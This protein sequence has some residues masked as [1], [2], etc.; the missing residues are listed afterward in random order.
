MRVRDRPERRIA[1]RREIERH[2]SV[3]S[4]RLH[5]VER[6]Q[7][8]DEV[9][10]MLAVGDGL[11]ERRLALLEEQRRYCRSRDRGGAPAPSITA[12]RERA[13]TGAACCAMLFSQQTRAD[14]LPAAAPWPLSWI[15]VR[16]ARWRGTSEVQLARDVASIGT[17][18]ESGCASVPDVSC[19]VISS[20]NVAG[21]MCMPGMFVIVHARRHPSGHRPSWPCWWARHQVL[22]SIAAPALRCR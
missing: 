11:D 2:S 7:L 1:H 22:G 9:V 21:S 12:R 20:R 6:R 3:R 13:Q 14:S 8:H 10:R 16:N 4:S 19:A 15:S 17:G 5:V 18:V